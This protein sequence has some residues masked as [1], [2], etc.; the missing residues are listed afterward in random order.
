[1]KTLLVIDQFFSANNGMT[2]SA[3][4]FATVLSTHG[5]E[6]RIASVGKPGDTQYLMD[7]FHVPVFDKLITSQGMTF[8]KTNKK[9]LTEAIEWCDVMHVLVPFA[10]S[11]NAIK[12][13]RKLK[14]PYTAA[15]HVQPEN[16]SSSVH[17]GSSRLINSMLYK[18]FDHYIYQYC[19]HVHCPSRFIA[20]ELIKHNY[21]SDLHI[22]SN[23][24]DP[25][26][27]YVRSD[28][29]EKYKDKLLVLSI[30]RLSVEKQQ[31][32]TLQAI[33]KSEY[34]DRIKFI[35]AGQGPRRSHLEKLAK[36][37][38]VDYEITFCK[39]EELITLI[40]Y[41]D[42]YVHA[43]NAEIEAMSCMEA[44]ACGLVPI[45]ANSPKSATPQ[46]A[47]CENSLFK[48]GDPNDLAKKI[49]Y[50]LSHPEEKAEYEQK[51]AKNAERYQLDSCVL[52]AEEMFL[53]A[54]KESEACKNSI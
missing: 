22:I 6:V 16:I 52:R 44:F 11:H 4:R 9:L 20:D 51:Y 26:F 10:L 31:H 29:P 19:P 8:A 15:F 28:K 2:I 54:I 12:I 39:K 37:L 40:S 13:A 32:V 17:L 18:W 7:E 21:R 36:K 48:V 34:K 25:D 14:K 38:G 30:G 33:S 50:W 42:L 47:L 49:D 35:M 1:M 46:F 41:C 3:R 27:K 24:I 5:H 45:I 53:T 23:G 43:A